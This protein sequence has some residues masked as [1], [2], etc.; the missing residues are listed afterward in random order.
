M[1]RLLALYRYIQYRVM[2]RHRYGVLKSGIEVSVEH[3]H[4]E[5]TH[6]DVVHP[7]VRYIVEGYLGHHWWMV[8]TPYYKSDASVENPILCYGGSDDPNTPPAEWKYYCIVNAKPDKG[9]NSDPTLLYN[10]K[11]LYVFWRE[12]YEHGTHSFCR[13]TFA[14]KV[15]KDGVKRVAKPLLVAYDAE[16]D[17]ETSPCFMPSKNGTIMAYGMHLRFHSPRIQRMKQPFKRFVSKITL[18]SDL[19]GF[20][21]QQKHYGL[22]VWHQTDKDW[23]IPYKHTKTIYFRN[24]NPLYRPWHMDFFDW[25]GRRYSVVQTNQCNADIVLSVSNDNERFTM[26][27]KPL[28]TNASIGKSGIYKPCAGVTTEGIFYLYYTAQDYDNRS[29]N[30]LYLTT[31]PMKELEP[32]LR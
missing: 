25:E 31:I 9:Y 32:L 5:W 2:R 16:E 10:N 17:T 27:D 12:N 3:F 21:S 24:C 8:Y 29:L 4:H 13:A 15:V 18:V 30:K 23:L 1:R 7:C 26:F 6:G 14:A 11:E 20:Y 19:L 22:A 28:I